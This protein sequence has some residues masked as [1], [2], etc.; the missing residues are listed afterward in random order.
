MVSPD[1]I[2]GLTDGEGCFYVGVRSPKGDHKTTRVEPHFYIKLKGDDFHLL[3]EVKQAFGC[4]AIYYQNEKRINHSACYRF[5]INS[6][7]D[8]RDKL[9]PFFEKHPLHSKKQREFKIFQTIFKLVE[10]KEYKTKKGLEKV[11]KLK[12][13]MNHRARWVREIRLPSGNGK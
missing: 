10:N 6:L 2:V 3:E 9:I 1:Y 4:G 12:L 7:K 11:K 8:L 5:E 13:M